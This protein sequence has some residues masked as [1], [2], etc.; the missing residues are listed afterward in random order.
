MPR[1]VLVIGG[2]V[3][4]LCVAYY[5]RRQ[6][7][8]VT[9]AER[10]GPGR[11]NCSLGNA[12]LVVPS[13]FV[14]LA[15]PGMVRLGLK[16]ML[17]PD[18]PFYFRPG[19]DPEV[20]RWAWRFRSAANPGHV[21]RAAPLLLRLNRESRRLYEELAGEIGG[22]GFETKGLLMLC[23]T[24]AA[25]R[26]EAE[27]AERAHR[28]GLAAEL[29]SP[30]ACEER[31]PGLRL[32]VAGGVYFPEDGHLVPEHL[33]AALER[34]V[35]ESGV[36][37]LESTEV[38][39]WR[40][41]NGRIEAVKTAGGEIAADAFVV[42][43]GAGSAALVRGLGL[44]LPMVAGKGYS[45][46]LPRPRQQLAVPA[47]LTEARVAVTPMG[48]ALRFAGTMEIGGADGAAHPARVR[49][50]LRSIPRYFPD[51]RPEDFEGVP[52]WRGHRPCSPDGLPY[53]GAFRRYGN[54]W[55]ATGHAMMGVSLAPVTG[56]LIAQM[57]AGDTA[58]PDLD[59]LSPDRYA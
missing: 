38:A 14:P 42:A 44:R 49:G 39:G 11:D 54:L 29:L 2:G 23:R 6:G 40:A 19:L 51:Y 37:F 56:H 52:A 35:K 28:L 32:S 59:A 36:R 16:M 9:L 31:E 7:L 20:W 43:A 48:D 53:V 21:E 47:I 8:E 34:A 24:D 26:E 12:G 22:F 25:L 33:A 41:G 18:S 50:I 15:A 13:H 27:V 10:G 55:A 1:S 45:L 5:A 58:L 3:V 57:L 30:K 46:T 4:G 17:R